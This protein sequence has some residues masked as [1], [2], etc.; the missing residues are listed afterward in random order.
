MIRVTLCQG[1]TKSQLSREQNN[2]RVSVSAEL[3]V[4]ISENTADGWEFTSLVTLLAYNL[5][6]FYLQLNN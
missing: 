4:S 6:T 2:H 5:P 1:G 3:L